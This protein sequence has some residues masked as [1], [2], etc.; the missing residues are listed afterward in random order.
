MNLP[1]IHG[2]QHYW[3]EQRI[4]HC[5][6]VKGQK[7]MLYSQCLNQRRKQVDADK[8]GVV[9]QPANLQR[10]DLLIQQIH[11][12]INYCKCS[13]SLDWNALQPF[14][15]TNN[16]N[17]PHTYP[18]HRSASSEHADHFS[19]GSYQNDLVQTVLAYPLAAPQDASH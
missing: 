18:K 4:G 7:Y 13:N 9:R 16:D 8:V 19:F 3:V 6:P 17:V 14:I 10:I 15:R 2:E 1:S 11:R 5:E 12:T